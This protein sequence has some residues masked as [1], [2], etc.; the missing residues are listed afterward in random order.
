MV[1]RFGIYGS[2]VARYNPLR[3]QQSNAHLISRTKHEHTM[4]PNT[5]VDDFKLC[6]FWWFLA[7]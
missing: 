6:M 1:S 4:K 3:R 2:G 5:L 7:R